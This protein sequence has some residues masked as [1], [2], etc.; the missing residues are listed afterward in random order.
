MAGVNGGRI[1]VVDDSRVNRI[2]LP[3]LVVAVS[4]RLPT[5]VDGS[6]ATGARAELLP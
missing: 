3:A 2:A 4:D 5:P 1:L 6:P